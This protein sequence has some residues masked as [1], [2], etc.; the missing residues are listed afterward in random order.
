MRRAK[1]KTTDE[2]LRLVSE[3]RLSGQTQKAW[4]KERGIS[5]RAFRDWMYKLKREEGDSATVGDPAAV[6]WVELK[7][8]GDLSEKGSSHVGFIEVF[9]GSCV[10]VVRPNFD[11]VLFSDVCRLLSGIC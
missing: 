5:L 6:N 1:V 10:V 9:I 4:C 2:W 11:S 7:D 3:Q 8:V